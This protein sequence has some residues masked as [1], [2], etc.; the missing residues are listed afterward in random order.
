[1]PPGP[2]SSTAPCRHFSGQLP[3]VLK[4]QMQLQVWVSA[5]QKRAGGTDHSAPDSIVGNGES[6]LQ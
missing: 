1:M 4:L 5:Q 6:R 3:A 2:S